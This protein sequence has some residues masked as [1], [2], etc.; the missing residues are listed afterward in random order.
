MRGD[1]PI[2]GSPNG[3]ARFASDKAGRFAIFRPRRGVDHTQYPPDPWEVGTLKP[4]G[5][6]ALK[7]RL[8]ASCWYH[9]RKRDAT[10]GNVKCAFKA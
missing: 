7:Y 9:Q 2:P 10:N 8:S 1:P 4:F 5:L 6:P 3:P